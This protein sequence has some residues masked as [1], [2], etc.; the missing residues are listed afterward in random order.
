MKKEQCWYKEVCINECSDSCMRF[1]CMCSLL[2]KSGLQEQRWKRTPLTAYNDDIE[3]FKVLA[4]IRSN[5]LQIVADGEDI[6]IWSNICG[7]G[8]TS[9]AI[10]ILLAYFDKI[11]HHS[12]FDCR[13]LFINVPAFLH[14]CKRNISRP[15]EK[16]EMLL[17]NIAN[18]DIVIWDDLATDTVTSYEYQLLFNYI[19]SRTGIH[20]NIFTSNHSPQDSVKCIG[21]RLSSRVKRS[22]YIVE[23]KEYDKRSM[24]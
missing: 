16:F 6:Y 18:C 15:T 5:I 9:W 22:K 2:E 12:G 10:N 19:D 7:N 20:T 1:N 13:G 21:E 4:N 8:K 17:D 14:D 3:A 24:A 11:W 23:L